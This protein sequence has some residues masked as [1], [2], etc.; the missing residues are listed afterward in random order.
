MKQE[1][2]QILSD[3]QKKIYH[4][5]YFLFGDEAHYIDKVVDYIDAHA[6]NESEKAFNQQVLYGKDVDAMQIVE[7]AA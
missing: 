5:I 6:L 2:N 1:Y 7:S 4:P 3:L